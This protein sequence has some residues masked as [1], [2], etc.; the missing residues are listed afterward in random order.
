MSVPGKRSKLWK[1]QNFNIH[2]PCFITK[3]PHIGYMDSPATIDGH[4]YILC[5]GSQYTDAEIT[6]C[7]SCLNSKTINKQIS[8]FKCNSYWK[9]SWKYEE[10]LL[11]AGI[12]KPS[13]PHVCK[14]KLCTYPLLRHAF[15]QM[16]KSIE[17]ATSFVAMAIQPDIV[18]YKE[19]HNP[20]SSHCTQRIPKLLEYMTERR[21]LWQ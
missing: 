2:K 12:P 10:T 6:Q 13:Q 7:N 5:P 8:S 3:H 16:K 17:K 18:L 20:A 11:M 1:H 19:G 21:Y 9:R 4:N 14:W 15:P